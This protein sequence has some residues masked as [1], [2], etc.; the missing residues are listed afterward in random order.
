M[1][2]SSLGCRALPSASLQTVKSGGVAVNDFAPIGRRHAAQHLLDYLLRVGPGAVVV[3]II[4]TPHQDIAARAFQGKDTGAVI[5]EYAFDLALEK[6]A[7]Q[8]TGLD[9]AFV[10]RSLA[11]KH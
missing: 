9:L 1:A 5:L 4:R 7:G 3:R 6:I 8:Q 11:H 2:V 10:A